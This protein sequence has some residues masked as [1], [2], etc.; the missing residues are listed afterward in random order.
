MYRGKRAKGWNIK[1]GI[2]LASLVLLIALTVGTTVAFLIDD[3][4]TVVNEFD[5]AHVSCK[6]EETFKES[7]KTDVK[8]Q[9]TG[10]ID[11]Y[12]R[13][14][15]LVNWVKAGTDK[16][17]P[18]VPSG[19]SYRLTLNSTHWTAE[20]SDGY[21]YYTTKVAPDAYTKP[22][23]DL[24]EP[25]YPT[26]VTVANAPYQLQVEIIAEAIQADGL[27]AASA[28]DAWDKAKGVQP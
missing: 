23:I 15:I 8:V 13:A 17:V 3:T 9:N 5:P 4:N 20:Q 12:I 10:D 7:K 19:Y 16:V 27:G 24:A 1:S 21:Y 22:L 26:G 28:Q 14:E 18:V 6:I 2:L 11:A 25:V